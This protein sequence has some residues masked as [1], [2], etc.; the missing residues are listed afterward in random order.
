MKRHI[1][2]VCRVATVWLASIGLASA[3][4]VTDNN[5]TATGLGALT[6]TTTVQVSTPFTVQSNRL[7]GVQATVTGLQF[8]TALTNY[9]VDGLSTNSITKVADTFVATVR[10][11]SP[12]PGSYSQTHNLLY[13]NRD[14]TGLYYNL[15]IARDDVNAGGAT[16]GYRFGTPAI[17]LYTPTEVDAG[18]IPRYGGNLIANASF[19]NSTFNFFTGGSFVSDAGVH[20]S[21]V[22][23]LTGNTARYIALPLVVGESYVLSFWYRTVA[24]STQVEYGFSQPANGLTVGTGNFTPPLSTT[25]TNIQWFFTPSSGQTT[26]YLGGSSNTGSI[27]FDSLYLGL[28]IVPEPSTGLLMLVGLGL[29]IRRWEAHRRSRL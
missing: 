7:I 26:L 18:L 14:T 20:G 27:R 2:F 1:Q 13:G 16:A 11:F 3:T 22:L 29:L 25:W 19:E 5:L 12:V 9:R 24:G 4:I 15:G 28:E 17:T 23:E 21:Q 8:G 6:N 10:G